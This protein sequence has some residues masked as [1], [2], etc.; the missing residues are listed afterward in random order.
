MAREHGCSFYY[1][2]SIPNTRIHSATEQGMMEN[3]S[4]RVVRNSNT[5]GGSHGNIE[6]DDLQS[7]SR[8]ADGWNWERRKMKLFAGASSVNRY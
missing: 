5:K 4:V 1:G 3:V 6:G 7:V 2:I 8:I